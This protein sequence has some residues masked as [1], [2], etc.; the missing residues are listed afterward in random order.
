MGRFQARLTAAVVATV[1]ACGLTYAQAPD[2]RPTLPL[3]KLD[4]LDAVKSASPQSPNPFLSLL[5]PGVQPDWAYWRA[6]L[7][8][9]AALQPPSPGAKG[10]IA[11]VE[12]NDTPATAMPLAGFGSGDGDTTELDVLGFI[13]S[14][15]PPLF[16]GSSNEDD[17]AIPLAL[18]S[19]VTTSRGLRFTGTI[20][21]GPFGVTSGDF[22]FYRIENVATGQL[23]TF[24]IDTPFGALD[25]FLTVWSSTGVFLDF[26]DDDGFSFDSFLEFTVPAPGTY[27]VSVGSFSSPFPFDPFDSSTGDGVGETGSYQFTISLDRANPDFYS[28]DLEAGDVFAVSVRNAADHVSLFDPAGVLRIATA[29]PVGIILPDAAPFPRDGNAMIPYVIEAAGT[30]TVRVLSSFS[31]SYDAQF[32]VYRPLLESAAPGERQILF[33]DFD[34]AFID[35]SI[36][37]F[38]GA[39]FQNL[40]PLSA[41]LFRWGLLP[42]DED[43]IIEKTLEVLEENLASDMRN[44]GNNGSFNIEILNSRD[45]TDPFGVEPVS[46]VIVGGT[47]D[48]SGIPTVGIAESIDVGNFDHSESALVLLDTLSGSPAEGFTFNGVPLTGGATKTDLIGTGLANVIA[49]EA[50]HFFGDFHT[51]LFNANI[52]I[53]D[54]GGDFDGLI[55]LGFDG[56]FGSFDD[57]DTDFGVDVYSAF[58]LFAGEEDTLNV[59][60]F[61]LSTSLSRALSRIPA[62]GFLEEGTRLE[63][64]A[65][66][67]ANPPY[68][69]L[70]RTTTGDF[71]PLAPQ[72]HLSGVN[73]PTLVFNALTTGDTG[74]YMLQ[75]DDGVTKTTVMSNPLFFNVVPAGALPATSWLALLLAATTIAF[76]A[77]RKSTAEKSVAIGD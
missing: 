67:E 40:S 69:W 36:F 63:L 45:H 52:N 17:G 14:P 12:P 33:V 27:Y 54:E 20:G 71:Q 2:A 46:R 51:R 24:D 15:G 25:S 16:G 8:A 23:I 48:E 29:F 62:G 21:D 3:R 37:G 60:A 75:F 73:G 66:T 5:P 59:V 6:K 28:V 38:G 41:F 10:I 19:N 47:I 43:A 57:H 4:S 65:P 61:G 7:R 22:D 74:T 77:W 42:S 55:G 58:E 64:L 76:T 18:N 50:G 9:D 56:V 44:F 31:G 35:T 39:G 11:E 72:A 70:K 13:P 68:Q 26:N 32:R 1:V 49:H 34:G 30:Y 53:M